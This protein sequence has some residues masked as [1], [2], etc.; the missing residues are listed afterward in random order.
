VTRELR[1]DALPDELAGG[2]AALAG[3]GLDST[4]EISLNLQSK[5]GVSSER[6][7]HRRDHGVVIAWPLRWCTVA[8]SA[9]MADT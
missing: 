8:M 1:A 7:S 6:Y 3:S 9:I 2:L 4:D 5:Q